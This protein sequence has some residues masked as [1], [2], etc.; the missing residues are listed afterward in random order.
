MIERQFWEDAK[1]VWI[2]QAPP[3]IKDIKAGSGG[4][5][6]PSLLKD[7]WDIEG[8]SFDMVDFDGAVQAAFNGGEIPLKPGVVVPNQAET[9]PEPEKPKR[10]QLDTEKFDSLL[11]KQ[12]LPDYVEACKLLRKCELPNEMDDLYASLIERMPV[13]Q[14]AIVKFESVYQSD[15]TQFYEYYIPEALQLTATYLEYLNAGIGDQ[16]I[17]ETEKEV[18]DAADKLLI[19]VNDKIDEIYKFASLEIKAKA[20][21]LESLMSQDGYVDPNFKI[22]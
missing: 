15:M 9:D 14:D 22:N 12:T 16:I 13:L 11:E 8:I 7:P 1:K 20:K 10:P 3:K 2:V 17:Q 4:N 5:I 19:A 21:A 6:D 18:L